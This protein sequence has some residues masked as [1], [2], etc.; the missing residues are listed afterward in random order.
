MDAL[1]LIFRGKSLAVSSLLEIEL[2]QPP[3][4]ALQFLHDPCLEATQPR[5]QGCDRQP[6]G[7]PQSTR[8]INKALGFQPPLKQWVDLNN[9]HC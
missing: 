6:G 9:H 3:A 2:P 5:N 4:S 1:G 7:V 8:L